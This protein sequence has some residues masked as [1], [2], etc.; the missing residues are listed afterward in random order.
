[1]ESVFEVRGL[2]GRQILAGEIPVR[3]SKNVAP[4]ALAM[5]PLFSDA[6]SYDGIPDIED[7]ASMVALLTASGISAARVGKRGW[8]LTP[9]I[10]IG[11][12]LDEEITKRFRA[13][14]LFVGPILART[15]EVI[16]THPGGDKI[17]A[18]PI[19]YFL[20]GF[21]KMGAQTKVTK[22]AYSV[23]APR[24][25]LR[26]AEI[27][28]RNAS[29]T[30]TQTLMMAGVLASGKTIIKNAAL[31]PEVVA[32]AKFLKSCGAK[33]FGEG[34][35]TIEIVGQGGKLLRSRGK[36][37]IT[38]PDRLETGSFLILAVLTG[39]DVTITNADPSHVESLLEFLSSIATSSIEVRGSS[40]R[41]R[42]TKP[43]FL[44]AADIKTH[45]YPGIATDFQPLLT[46]LL[47]QADGKSLIFETIFEG[48][49]SY[50]GNLI[51]MGASIVT[52]DPHRIIV[53]GKTP[54]T[55]LNLTSPDI[56]AG[57]AYLLSAIIAKGSSVIH[58]AYCIDR[59]YEKI[60]DRLSR[61]GVWIRR[62][63]TP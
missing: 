33:I 8:K 3:G 31:E 30:G 48:R 25:G 13:S 61:L 49:F 23:R 43:L 39:K 11:S 5:S 44:R 21:E 53:S 15:G 22:K 26:G 24:G 19:D 60:E 9:G 28:L 55:G 40:I 56:R 50:V 17:G 27:F 36:K 34:T 37:F 4:H 20:E 16:F 10:K 2:S 63:I 6:V 1:M 35:T 12:V 57:L 45:E 42:N 46:V 29:V 32:L 62:K 7:V 52:C 38:M 51:Q 18:R 59:G 41:V 54:L 47:T 14:V 58:N